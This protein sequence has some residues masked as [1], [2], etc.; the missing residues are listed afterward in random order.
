MQE[1]YIFI[2]IERR[3]LIVAIILIII[4]ISAPIFVN[5]DNFKIYDLLYKSLRDSDKELLLLSSIRL[6][7]LNGIRG[8]PHYLGTFIIAE[9]IDIKIKGKSI[10]H[11]KGIIAVIIIPLVYSAINKIHNIK[12]DLGVPAFIVI[13]AIFYL[14][15]MN[16]SKI[17]FLKK[18]IIIISLL[19]GVQWLDVVPQIQTLKFGRGETSQDIKMIASMIDATYIL[20]IVSTMFFLL[21]TINALLITKLI[22]DEQKILVA[23]EKNS[24]VE[25]ELNE[26]RVAGLEARHYIELKN[27]VHDL[28]TPL[29]SIQALISVIMLMEKDSKIQ[30]YLYKIQDSIDR[31]NEMISEILYKEKKS[32][33]TTD[34]LFNYTFA[35]ISHLPFASNIEY[36]NNSKNVCLK[37]N[38][39]RFARAIINIIENSYN[40]LKDEEDK[41]YIL[42]YSVDNVIKMEFR[43]NGIGIKKEYIEQIK[44]R[45]FS[46]SGSTGLGLSFIED[47]VINHNGVI[48]L[49][50]QYGVGTSI[51]IE[52]PSVNE[53]V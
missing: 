28:K 53:D 20:G 26:A 12:Y 1:K 38:K 39:I 44:Q 42:V 47:V 35:N 6:V 48:N 18:S 2:N 22:G 23:N 13:F 43:D 5:V 24:I 17:S 14:E 34:E 4:G 51:V 7:L 32:I 41:I 27:L 52:L 8:L 16:Y 10:P 50:S 25:K 15:K 31:L 29:T 9:S 21:F 33:I 46:K 36:I 37:V 19:L 3:K 30:N 40:A 49:D 45:G 11:I